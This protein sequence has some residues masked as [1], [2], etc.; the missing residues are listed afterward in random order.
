MR[1]RAVVK[2]APAEPTTARTAVGFSG[3]VTQPFCACSGRVTVQRRA[4]PRN[5]RVDLFID[6]SPLGEGVGARLI[7]SVEI[8]SRL[9]HLGL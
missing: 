7:F 4:R 3:E 9:Y 2:N 8:L 1:A 6:R 5:I